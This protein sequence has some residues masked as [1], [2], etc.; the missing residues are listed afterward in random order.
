MRETARGPKFEIDG[1]Y[2]IGAARMAS[3]ARSTCFEGQGRRHAYR[4]DGEPRS[5]VQERMI[6]KRCASRDQGVADC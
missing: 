4:A 6:E 2:V 3:R 5:R 1:G